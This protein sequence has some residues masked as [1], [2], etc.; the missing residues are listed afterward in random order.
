MDPVASKIEHRAD[1]ELDVSQNL[2]E[3]VD[4]LKQLSGS[5]LQLEESSIIHNN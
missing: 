4:M 3:D 5:T 2:V 1:V